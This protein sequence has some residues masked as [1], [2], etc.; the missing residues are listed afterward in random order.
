MSNRAGRAGGPGVARTRSL[1]RGSAL[2]MV[3]WLSAALA[4]IALSVSATV[5]AETEHVSTAADGLR[6]WYLATGS[7]ERA[8]QYMMWGGLEGPDRYWNRRKSRINFTYPSGEAVVE[9][10]AESGKLNVLTASQGDLMRVI[11]AVT[12]DGSQASKIAGGLGGRGRSGPGPTFPGGGAS[13]QEIEDLLT[14]PGMTPEVFYGNYIADQSGR[15]FARGGL[16]D[17][18]S[19]WGSTSGPFDV[20]AAS[21]ALLVAFGATEEGA[22]QLVERRKQTPF[23]TIGDA[24]GFLGSNNGR[25]RVGGNTIY[26]VRAT[27]RLRLPNGQ[28][29]EVVRTASAVVKV[30]DPLLYSPNSVHVLR[31]YDDAWSQDAAAPPGPGAV[32]GAPRQ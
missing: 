4:A 24:S 12:S 3:L 28:P 30:L 15:L 19:V 8:I 16:R 18:L 7:V 23:K 13:F 31:F 27:A 17:C 6:A 2:L 21:P 26:T 29:S 5:R 10:M 11:S 25:F 14:L 20:N 1:Q 32:P 22:L 9:I